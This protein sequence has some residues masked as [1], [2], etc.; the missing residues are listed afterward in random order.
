MILQKFGAGAHFFGF[1]DEA[2]LDML[3]ELLQREKILGLFCEFPSNPLLKCANMK[4]LRLLAN[5]HGFPIV[6][7]DTLGNFKNIDILPFADVVVTS[8]TKVFSGDSNVMGGRC[9][10]L[11]SLFADNGLSGFL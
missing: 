7:D 6:V 10:S 2:E 11:I 3:E 9:E 8:L 4:R 1:G 5:L